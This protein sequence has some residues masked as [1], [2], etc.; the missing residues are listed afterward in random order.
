MT[1]ISVTEILGLVAI[2]VLFVLWLIIKDGGFED[3]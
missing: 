2:S 3:E 1:E